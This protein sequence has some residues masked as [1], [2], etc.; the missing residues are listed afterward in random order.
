LFPRNLN[1]G[2]E[3]HAKSRGRKNAPSV[4]E[5]HR[6]EPADEENLSGRPPE[7][8]SPRGD[9]PWGPRGQD[10]RPAQAG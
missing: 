2:R 1:Q 10:T 9:A 4:E 3:T 6:H 7:G 5:N 8:I